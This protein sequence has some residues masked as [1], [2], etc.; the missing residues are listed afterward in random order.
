MGS[1]KMRT[2]SGSW[3]RFACCSVAL[4]SLLAAC[5][6][7]GGPG[8][9]TTPS[10]VPRH[11][12]RPVAHRPPPPT[13]HRRS[14]A[15]LRRGHRRPELFLQTQRIG[16]G[17][18]Q[19]HVHDCEQARVGGVRRR[20]GRAHRHAGDEGCRR[21]RGDRDRGDRRQKPSPPCPRSRITVAA[22]AAPPTV[23]RSPGRRRRRTQTVRRSRTC[24]VT[25]STTASQSGNYTDSVAV[26]NAGLTRYALATLP[27]GTV[28]I[29][30]TAVN[31]AGAESDFSKEVDCHGELSSIVRSNSIETCDEA[32]APAG[33]SITAVIAGC[34][35]SSVDEYQPSGGCSDAVTRRAASAAGQVSVRVTPSRRATSVFAS[36]L[37]PH[38]GAKCQNHSRRWAR[39]HT[40]SSVTR[41][42][43]RRR[44]YTQVRRWRH[45]VIEP[46][47]ARVARHHPHRILGRLERFDTRLR[48]LEPQEVSRRDGLVF[49]VH[50]Q[51]V[52]RGRAAEVIPPAPLG[53]IREGARV[54]EDRQPR[55]A[56]RERQGIG[57]A[58]R[59]NREITERARVRD[60]TYFLGCLKILTQYVVATLGKLP[61]HGQ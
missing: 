45:R 39:R 5:G 48:V 47:V 50:P 14:P 34:F 10:T 4:S 25:R 42:L 35:R 32:P 26:T 43:R 8:S 30:M 38:P 1:H 20:H 61:P 22:A 44:S 17:Q 12:R 55:S 19:G 49:A 59:R 7:G 21:L 2:V 11:R 16:R 33:A 13:T 57:M 23:S 6:G 58:V 56:Q 15:Q 31:A 24:R 41:S 37:T 40:T 3:V 29:A 46:L 28:Y 54:D 27:K 51:R 18:G 36:T 9:R 53:V 52:V 60:D